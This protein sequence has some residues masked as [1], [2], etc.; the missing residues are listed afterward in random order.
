MRFTILSRVLLPRN[1]YCDFDLICNYALVMQRKQLLSY[2]WLYKLH[3][4]VGPRKTMNKFSWRHHPHHMEANLVIS[5]VEEEVFLLGTEKE[6]GIP[7][8]I[9]EIFF[10]H[11]IIMQIWI[12]TGLNNQHFCS[13]G[14][15]KS[16][17]HTFSIQICNLLSTNHSN[18]ICP[19][20]LKCL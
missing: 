6:M 10:M 16:Y 14:L 5:S 11:E 19:S 13:N 15:C 18:N 3:T 2:S 7:F 12:D 20:L 9:F 1:I 4:C 17:A 8:L